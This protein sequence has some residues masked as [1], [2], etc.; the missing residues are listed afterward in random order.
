M[1]RRNFLKLAGTGTAA[2]LTGATAHRKAA[3]DAAKV[4][5]KAE[6]RLWKDAL[7]NRNQ[8][9]STVIAQHG[10]VCAS[11]P[12]AAMAGID[13]LKAGGNC[14]DAAIA[15][16]AMLGLTEPASNGIGGDLFAI[17][18]VEADQKLYGL[19]ASGRAPYEWTLQAALDLKLES[20]PRKSPLAWSVPGCVSGWAMLN[21][22]FGKLPLA[23]CL[24][25]TIRYATEGFPISPI[26]AGQFHVDPKEDPDLAKLFMPDGKE[27]GFGDVY[28]NPLLARSLE[29]IAKNGAPAFYEGEIAQRI[30]EKSKSLGGKMELRDLKEH[31]AN[32]VDPVSSSYRGHDVW[33]IPP[34]GQGICAL[35]MLN[36]LENFDIASLKPNSAEHLHLLVE[37]KKL[38]FEDRAH[39]YA[40]P[41]FAKVPVEWL[42]SKDYAAQRAKLIN[43]KRAMDSVGHGDPK[44]DSDT[45]YLCAADG[46]GNMISFI[47]SLYNGHGSGLVPE[48]V[49]F[50][51]Q[52]RG[53]AFALDPN[54]N[55]RLEP[56]KRPFHTIIPA[57]MTVDGKP[58][59]AFG[60]M[61]GDFQPQ[62][63]TQ[64]V[65]NTVD[66]NMSPQQAG[67]Q[68][69]VRHLG[70][71]DFTGRPGEGAGGWV[72]FELNIAD[73]T[74]LKMA[75][76]GHRISTSRAAEGGYQSIWREDDP[77]VYFGGSDPR[78][79][80]AALGY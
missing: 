10:M 34:N 71:S 67:D 5:P 12:L 15:A 42:I 32:W 35:Q 72:A 45:I 27:L 4:N 64:V 69:R 41:E 8:N 9:R 54:H 21:D 20:I 63:H 59:W 40:D 55:N 25:P 50:A 37:A 11:Q 2:A 38:A 74:R 57:F 30:V 17:L 53:Q 66:F 56:H 1:D 62:G 43:L 18:W 13:I 48:G 33:E 19:N 79:D 78:K 75:E 7:R 49:G 61:G 36:I 28:R 31:T 23:K 14:V 24:E 29:R 65:I 22:R 3:A 44:L 70:S 52:N 6:A 16:N 58:R 26:I 80:G 51:I 73:D 76:L 60:V 47:Q 77:L 68:P 39:F 46:Q